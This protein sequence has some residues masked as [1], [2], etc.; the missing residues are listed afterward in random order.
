MNNRT[1]VIHKI[2]GKK[3]FKGTK[4]DTPTRINKEA[5]GAEVYTTIEFKGKNIKFGNK[6]PNIL[7]IADITHR[8]VIKVGGRW[9]KYLIGKAVKEIEYKAY[10]SLNKNI[11]ISN[12]D[13]NIAYE[14][15][16]R[17]EKNYG[18][19]VQKMT[20]MKNLKLKDLYLKIKNIDGITNVQFNVEGIIPRVKQA[21]FSGEE[22]DKS[23]FTI[24]IENIKVKCNIK[25]IGLTI[26]WG[27]KLDK[28]IKVKIS[29]N[30]WVTFAEDYP[31]ETCLEFI[32]YLMG[33]KIFV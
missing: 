11:F 8:R 15:A 32:L 4:Y 16:K 20:F 17:L 1:F 19:K 12:A 25:Y 14:A 18:L 6:N 31:I 22:L 24:D 5:G 33:Q 26:L 28:K 13:K 9:D 27:I 30:G 10:Y 3:F 21:T 7:K 23:S 29:E 2:K